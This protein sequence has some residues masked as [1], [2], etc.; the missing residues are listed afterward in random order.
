MTVD[1]QEPE[2]RFKVVQKTK[3][4]GQRSFEAVRQAYLNRHWSLEKVASI[5][6]FA[7]APAHR[8]SGLYALL[9][10]ALVRTLLKVGCN[11]VLIA[12]VHMSKMYS[13]L[14]SR[15]PGLELLHRQDEN[16]VFLGMSAQ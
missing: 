13:I 4:K 1:S 9:E 14:M 7:V 12:T 10:Q 11:S 5:D 8:E 16:I 3:P 15:F 2:T 6:G